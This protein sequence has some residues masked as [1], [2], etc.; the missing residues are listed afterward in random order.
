[1]SLKKCTRCA[2]GSAERK[3]PTLTECLLCTSPSGGNSRIQYTSLNLSATWDIEIIIIKS[4]DK[5]TEVQTFLWPL[6]TRDQ[7]HAYVALKGPINLSTSSF[8]Y[9]SVSTERLG[10]GPLREWGWRPRVGLGRLLSSLFSSLERETSGDRGRTAETG[11]R[12]GSTVPEWKEGEAGE[13]PPSYTEVPEL[14]GRN[15]CPNLC[16]LVEIQA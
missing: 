3:Q 5:E 6:G 14:H 15:F 13:L 4:I 9:S 16:F 7:F 1:M 2:G 10:V 11:R 12:L 8:W